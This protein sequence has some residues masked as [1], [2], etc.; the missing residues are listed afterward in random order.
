MHWCICERECCVQV[1][2][3]SVII[4]VVVHEAVH[5]IQKKEDT[6]YIFGSMFIGSSCIE[7]NICHLPSTI[8]CHLIPL[9]R[10][11][12]A[13]GNMQVRRYYHH[14]II[15]QFI[16]KASTHDVM[17]VSLR[18]KSFIHLCFCSIIGVFACSYNI[19]PW[20]Y[21]LHLSDSLRHMNQSPFLHPWW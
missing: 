6:K 13:F 10:I 7:Q 16:I 1:H 9:F 17:S 14:C 5:F 12:I 4:I 19:C 21:L 20:W 11:S 8:W 2:N 18:L 15:N 3:D